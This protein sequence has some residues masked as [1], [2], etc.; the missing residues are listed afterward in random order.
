MK[1]KAFFAL[2]LID[3]TVDQG[4]ESNHIQGICTLRALEPVHRAGVPLRLPVLRDT[5]S[6]VSI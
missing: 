1:G 5:E 6:A 4:V 2:R 3:V